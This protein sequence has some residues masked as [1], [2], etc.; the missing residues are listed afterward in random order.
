MEA[1]TTLD[2]QW[3][4]KRNPI[5]DFFMR[6][7]KEKPLGTF[8]F[9]LVL[10]LFITGVFA[11]LLAPF[12]YNDIHLKDIL[13]SPSS[14]YWLGTDGMGRDMLSR[15]IYGA[16]IS[17]IV[18]VGASVS[19]TVLSA[20]IGVTSGFIGGKFDIIMPR[21]VDAWMAFP[22]LVILLTI[23]SLLGPGIWQIILVLTVMFGIGSSRVKR[24]AVIAIKE[25]M[26]F[27]A[28]TSIG[29][30]RMRILF[31]HVLPNI[32]PIML[33]TFTGSMAAIILTESVLSFVGMGIPPPEPSWGGMLGAG[34]ASML[35]APW[36]AIWPGLAISLAVFGIN[37]F[38]DAIR[39]LLDPRMRGGLGRF[40]VAAKTVKDKTRATSS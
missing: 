7:F 9:V 35:R 30:S 18:G 19:A 14:T 4:E 16:R 38:G 1:P 2:K 39:D 5:I 15:L 36:M 32:M 22:V 6:L 40:G 17:M 11:D 25:N 26:Y 23:M 37:M 29:C 21:F 3:V 33:V 24:S 27:A 10:I 13:E 31:R 20:L 12:G 34:R 8:G 28:A